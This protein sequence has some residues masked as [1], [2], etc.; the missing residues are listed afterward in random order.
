VLVAVAVAAALAALPVAGRAAPVAGMALF[1]RRFDKTG[2]R[3]L[4]RDENLCII[5][6]PNN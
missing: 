5:V 6:P 2:L 3:T 4:P 1:A